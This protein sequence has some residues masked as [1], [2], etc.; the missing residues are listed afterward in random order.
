MGQIKFSRC[1][2]FSVRA[3]QPCPAGL[4]F[5]GRMVAWPTGLTSWTGW[6]DEV[7][8]RSKIER[9]S[10]TVVDGSSL[11]GSVVGEGHF[12][13][14]CE[15]GPALRAHKF[16]VAVGSGW[17]SSRVTRP[18]GRARST[19]TQVDRPGP[20]G[21]ADAKNG[22]RRAR[23]T[24]WSSDPR[25]WPTEVIARRKFCAQR[26]STKMTHFRPAARSTPM[27]SQIGR[28]SCTIVDG[29][30]VGRTHGPR[31]SFSPRVQNRPRAA[32]TEFFH[33]HRTGLTIDPVGQTEWA[34]GVGRGD[35]FESPANLVRVDKFWPRPSPPVIASAD[36]PQWSVEPHSTKNRASALHR[37]GPST[38]SKVT[39]A[40]HR[41][42]FSPR[43]TRRGEN[44][45]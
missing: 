8:I 40:D 11:A 31:R 39:Q 34:A 19:G 6:P 7:V 43:S 27:R 23:S 17:S 26:A 9:V 38:R 37:R 10:H 22:P 2:P 33:R 18:E 4:D 15:I 12:R 36:P 28:V 1:E 20:S 44:L 24:H 25:R 29:T 35:F 32:R 14:R 41:R 42:R 5:F 3:P 13:L 16:F 21:Q 30:L 45:L